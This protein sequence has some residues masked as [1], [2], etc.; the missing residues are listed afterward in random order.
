MCSK[1]QQTTRRMTI[2]LSANS[3]IK[4]NSIIPNY[5]SSAQKSFRI[6]RL[7]NVNVI[8]CNLDGI[9]CLVILFLGYLNNFDFV[10]IKKLDIN[11]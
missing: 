8:Y 9:F 7:N 3:A 4:L 6:Q 11:T 1:D 2:C 5:P 10:V